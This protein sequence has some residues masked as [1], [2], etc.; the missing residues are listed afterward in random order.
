MRDASRGAEVESEGSAVFGAGAIR[1]RVWPARRH[2]WRLAIALMLVIGVAVGVALAWRN[3]W[4][5][6]I[7]ALGV[8]GAA[9]AYFFPTE[10]ALDGARLVVRQL[11]TPRQYDLRSFRRVEVVVDVVARAELGATGPNS[12]LDAVQ[13]VA[14]PLP[15]EKQAQE[16]VVAH[17]RRWVGRRATGQFAF[18][19]DHAPDDDVAS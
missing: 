5:A 8:S 4:W 9:V 13:A 15:V 3:G 17:M 14:V 10:V 11:G 12:P 19:D 18:D 2:P 16:R 7:A 6:A 1:Y